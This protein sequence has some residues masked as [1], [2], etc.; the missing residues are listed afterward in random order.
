MWMELP[1][2][3][4]PQKRATVKPI[5][6]E[7][8]IVI[9]PDTKEEV[10]EKNNLRR[11]AAAEDS[12][13]KSYTAT[14]T[15][16]SKEL[17]EEDTQTDATAFGSITCDSV[18]KI[19]GLN[20]T[21]SN[22][23]SL[24]H[25]VVREY[26]RLVNS[27]NVLEPQIQKLFDEQ[28]SAK[29]LEFRRR[30]REG[31]S[32][33]HIQAEAFAVVREAAK[34]KLGMHHFDVQIIGGAVLHDG[35]I[36]EMKTG[37][38][39]TL[40][41]TLAAY[42]NALTGEGVH[43]VTVNDYLAQR[44]AEWMGRVHRFL[45][46]SVGLIQAACGLNI[47]LPME[48]IED[49]DA[50]DVYNESAVVEYA[51]DIYK[52]YKEA[53]ANHLCR[54]HLQGTFSGN[55]DPTR[56]SLP[57]DSVMTGDGFVMGEGAGVLGFWKNLSMR[58]KEVQK[59]MLNISV[60]ELT[61][62]AG[63][64]TEFQA[65]LRLFWPGPRGVNYLDAT[66]I[67][68]FLMHYFFCSDTS[69]DVH[70]Q[71]LN[72]EIFETIYYHAL[73]ASSDLAAKEVRDLEYSLQG[74]LQPD[75]WVVTPS[76]QWDWVALR[77]KIEKNEVRNSLLAA[78]MPTAS[79]SQ[80]LGNNEC[81]EPHTSDIYSRRVLRNVLVLR[82]WMELLLQMEVPRKPP[83]QKRATMKPI[84][85]EA[86]IVIS[87]DA[88]EEVKEKNSLR[89]KA[90]AEDS[91]RKTYTAT[92]TAR[93]KAACGL[94]IKLP[95]EKIEDID[96]GDVYNELAVLVCMKSMYFG[97]ISYD[98]HQAYFFNAIEYK[99]LA[100]AMGLGKTVMT[101]AL[102]L[103]R[104]GKG[105]P[106]NQ[107]LAEDM[108]ITQH[109]RNR[110]IKG[111]TLIDELEAHSKP[112]SISV[113]VHYG[114]DI[115]NDPKV[116]AEPDVVLT[117]YGLLTAAYKADGGSS[118]F[119]K[120][121]W[122]RIVLDEAHTIKS[123]RTMS[124][125]A[126]FTLSVHCSWALT[127]TPLQNNVQNLYSLLCFLHVEPWCNWGMVGQ[128]QGSF[129][130]FNERN[131]EFLTSETDLEVL[132]ALEAFE[133]K[134]IN[135][136]HVTHRRVVKQKR[137]PK[138][139]I[140]KL[141]DV[142]PQW[143][144]LQGVLDKYKNAVV[145]IADSLQLSR[146]VLIALLA[147][148][149]WKPFMQRWI[150]AHIMLLDTKCLIEIAERSPPRSAENIALAIGALCSHEHECRQCAAAISLGLIS[151]FLHVTDRKQKVEYINALL[152]DPEEADKLLKIQRELDE[153][154][155]ILHETIDSVRERGEK[156]DSLVQKSSDLSTAPQG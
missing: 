127:G 44:D 42:L 156:L 98:S 114:G 50:R 149:S 23:T 132:R 103:A 154:K 155:I 13:R 66:V 137:L 134:I 40:V 57:L 10:K 12:S 118:I 59:S 37:E 28:L 55:N 87:P 33:S 89:R 133:V 141:L 105:I 70:A 56:A 2:K 5:K 80:I 147:L 119:H 107:E 11:K 108:A 91:S 111:G 99:I 131:L 61:L 27:V 14:L 53:E 49:I 6:P 113:F 106:D 101:I 43:V 140:E 100:D 95:K 73:K 45:G 144:A 9:S 109:S 143:K 4:P 22:I 110:R 74:T 41:S 124:A 52:F 34:R 92:V 32:I 96:A 54:R 16:R 17:S 146:N 18:E 136:E 15:A 129:P 122:H 39:K 145:E 24:N 115:S 85:P 151:S 31:E 153:T 117:T 78:P 120:V 1:R 83:S 8:V 128:F 150:K 26:G 64:L 112:D 72:K 102:I 30:L 75:I 104:L 67:P 21:W 121:D 82:M 86:V 46:L 123:W 25:W 152:E 20:K 36:A 51:E 7:A 35:A 71:D 126:A 130:D 38:G 47:K 3:P 88:K 76:N 48:K 125:R 84:K 93:S 65:L 81:F 29:T 138:S 69:S 63:D 77:A 116:I 94:N 135:H 148:Q 97:M 142:F 68:F 90:A 139:K 60:E 62:K 79:T 58:R 19:D